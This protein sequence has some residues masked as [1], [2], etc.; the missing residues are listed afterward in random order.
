MGV[1]RGVRAPRGESKLLS[2]FV[3]THRLTRPLSSALMVSLTITKTLIV[4]CKQS[5]NYFLPSATSLLLSSLTAAQKGAA[6]GK[7]D[8][9]IAARCASV[10]YAISTSTDP[11]L[12]NLDTSTRSN[13]AEILKQL[14]ALARYPTPPFAAGLDAEDTNR[15]RLI[16][17]GALGGAVSGDVLYQS[18]FASQIALILPALLA[19]ISPSSSASS[20]KEGA[21][22]PF[23]REESQRAAEGKPLTYNAWRIKRQPI[24]VRRVPSIYDGGASHADG[25]KGPSRM[26][27]AS[28]AIGVL[29]ALFAHGDANQIQTLVAHTLD[30]LDGGS[31]G[32]LWDEEEWCVWLGMTLTQWSALQ[33]RFVIV[34]AL[35]DHLIEVCDGKPTT[36]AKSLISMIT[37]ILQGDSSL[38]GLSTSDVVNN[39]LGL[40]V[41][42]V[43]EDLDD[44]LLPSLVEAVG[45]LGK[46]VYYAEQMTD[47]A[48]EICARI[49]MLQMPDAEHQE[50][51]LLFTPGAGMDRRKSFAGAPGPGRNAGQGNKGAPLKKLGASTA[52]QKDESIRVLLYCLITSFRKAHEAQAASSNNKGGLKQL[53][54][55]RD[56]I[57]ISTLH[58]VSGLLSWPSAVARLPFQQTLALFLELEVDS[59]DLIH[60]LPSEV[61]QNADRNIGTLHALA[62]SI[63]VTSLARALF[64]PDSLKQSPLEALPIV[65]R[66]NADVAKPI[67][68]DAIASANPVDYSAMEQLL[69]TFTEKVP[70]LSAFAFVPM[71][72]KLEK[73]AVNR[74]KTAAGSKGGIEAQRLYAVKH[75]VA[76]AYQAIGAK[77]GVS[78]IESS[79]AKVSTAYSLRPCDKTINAS[80]TSLQA[81]QSV[82]H[83]EMKLPQAPARLSPPDNVYQF[84]DSSPPSGF[85]AS[86]LFP[87]IDSKTLVS[88]LASN[89]TLQRV[90]GLTSSDLQSWFSRDWN[91]TIAIDDSFIRASPFN[92]D[93]PPE[94]SGPNTPARRGSVLTGAGGIGGGLVANTYT[95]GGKPGSI[96][97][98][99]SL[100]SVQ[101]SAAAD[102]STATSTLQRGSVTG[103]QDLRDALQNKSTFVSGGPVNG[104]PN[105]GANAP[106]RRASKRISRRAT[107]GNNAGV[108]GTGAIPAL[109]ESTSVGGILDS[110]N[111]GNGSAST[112]TKAAG[113]A[114]DS[115][116]PVVPPYAA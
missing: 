61:S 88:A 4:E 98:N 104:T 45:A 82:P 22:L 66:T 33:Y 3:E 89:D 51:A 59:I 65:D 90:T 44:P 32:R 25:E 105:G 8:L 111:L 99:G 87:V 101:P 60:E 18:T 49:E 70:V 5:L 92:E 78:S 36:Q 42:R 15:A 94:A 97:G 110:F 102:E 114:T 84:R 91:V 47:I 63:Y 67:K 1:E 43:H 115:V 26:D 13:Y 77:F 100:L 106:D 71:L 85:D 58:S 93:L 14:A 29:Q 12:A 83:A 17:V 69:T 64:V 40:S 38:I 21:L 20:E 2:N 24:A 34:S 62:A 7:L 112:E 50:A 28:A 107:S 39:L 72:I 11:Q 31:G 74:L 48:E 56:K 96:V 116:N 75:L 108:P 35:S 10:F 54:S 53:G 52:Q 37:A 46:H 73:D 41:R 57:P 113:N 79:A 23:L 19:N 103:I 86:K 16:G 95:P 27:V 55:A 80:L 30:F 81:M 68:P 76:A 109:P 6:G 9:D